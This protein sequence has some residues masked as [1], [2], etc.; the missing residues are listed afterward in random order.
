MNE[1]IIGIVGAIVGALVIFFMVPKKSNN[2]KSDKG[3]VEKRSAKYEKKLDKMSDSDIVDM[4]DNTDD[5]HSVS[6]RNRRRL[7]DDF[8]KRGIID[9]ISGRTGNNRS[10]SD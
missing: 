1:I 10:D 9:F 7:F 4:L 6:G 3:F 5:I 2:K 8:H